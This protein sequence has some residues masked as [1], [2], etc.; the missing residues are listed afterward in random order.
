MCCRL[1]LRFGH[2]RIFGKWRCASGGLFMRFVRCSRKHRKTM[3]FFMKLLLFGRT[4]AIDQKNWWSAPPPSSSFVSRA[5]KMRLIVHTQF[6]V[7]YGTIFR[8]RRCRFSVFF[9]SFSLKIF[10][11]HKFAI[12]NWTQSE[13]ERTCRRRD[14]KNSEFFKSKQVTFFL[15]CRCLSWIESVAAHGLLNSE[16]QFQFISFYSS[17][18]L[19]EIYKMTSQQ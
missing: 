9:L 6:F 5:R 19:K 18:Y 7:C 16:N 13:Q 14:R 2:T 8:R 10:F 15:F 4:N 11:C 17:F 1:T 12:H 3:S